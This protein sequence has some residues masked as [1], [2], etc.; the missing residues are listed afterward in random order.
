MTQD[1]LKWQVESDA[2]TIQ[3]YEE[4]M[5]DAARLERAKKYL[6]E[7]KEKIELDL[8]GFRDGKA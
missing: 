6:E 7:K 5:G 4:L 2:R 3:R 1:E 8:A